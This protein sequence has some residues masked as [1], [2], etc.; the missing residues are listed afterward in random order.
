MN[1]A[2]LLIIAAVTSTSNEQALFFKALAQRESTGNIKAWNRAEDACGLYQIRRIYVD[3]VNKILSRKAFSYSDRWDKAK[4]EQIII[5][6]LRHYAT[7]KRL[8]Y[9]PTWFDCAATHNGGPNGARKAKQASKFT[10][11]LPTWLGE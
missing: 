8:G 4:S 10:T 11:T 9:T 7:A 3:D 6:Y 2:V 1:A 5:I